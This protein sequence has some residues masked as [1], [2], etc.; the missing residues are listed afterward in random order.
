MDHYLKC[1]YVRRMMY[2][3]CQTQGI[4][5]TCSTCETNAFNGRLNACWSSFKHVLVLNRACEGCRWNAC[6][7]LFE[8]RKSLI[9][10]CFAFLPNTC[11]HWANTFSF[12]SECICLIVKRSWFLVQT[13]LALVRTRLASRLNAFGLSSDLVCLLIQTCLASRPNVFV[14]SSK[15]VWLLVRACLA[16]CP[17]AFVF[18]FEGGWL[19]VRT[20]PD[21]VL[22]SFISGANAFERQTHYTLCLTGTVSWS[23]NMVKTQCL[24]SR[25][26]WFRWTGHVPAQVFQ[27][28]SQETE[29][30]GNCGAWKNYT[31]GKRLTGVSNFAAEA[32]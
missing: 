9:R 12:L 2:S 3:T 15:R 19:L 6:R 4:I 21:I 1:M 23:G 17:N 30:C 13:H 20:H 8:C 28:H 25:L 31:S 10:M 7:L 32:P 22:N 26:S 14:F 18:S 24:C 11:R 16:S 27:S 29:R 5:Q